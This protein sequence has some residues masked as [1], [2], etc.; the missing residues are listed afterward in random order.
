MA[1]RTDN[2]ETAE[3][4]DLFLI[5]VCIFLVFG[6]KFVVFAAYLENILVV[7][8]NVRICDGYILF[9]VAF[10]EQSLI[11]KMFRI[12]A[13]HDVG[14]SSCHIGSYG[15]ASFTSR[16]SYYISLAL[17]IFSVENLVLY[18]SYVYSLILFED[19]SRNCRKSFFVAV[20]N[21]PIL[22]VGL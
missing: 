14:A 21:A 18:P 10:F 17:V 11:G 7:R 9:C 20:S 6:V 22:F 2:T 8:L 16:L 1:F 13:E 3:L 4:Y 15:D 5:R 12:P 19:H